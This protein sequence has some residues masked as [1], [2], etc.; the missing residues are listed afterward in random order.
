MNLGERGLN[1]ALTHLTRGITP[2]STETLTRVESASIPAPETS[3]PLPLHLIQEN[4]N[5]E[6]NS[7]SDFQ[8]AHFQP[9]AAQVLRAFF[10][11][12]GLFFILFNDQLAT[13]GVTRVGGKTFDLTSIVNNHEQ[14]VSV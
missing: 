1:C 4:S 9:P 13:G 12:I 10:L 2:S 8:S 7:Y 11:R 6:P 14:K 3:V 5:W